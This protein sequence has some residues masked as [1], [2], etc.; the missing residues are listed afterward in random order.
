M[1]QR[2]ENRKKS[3]W[4]QKDRKWFYNKT[5]IIDNMRTVLQERKN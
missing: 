1:E 3:H 2:D 5:E 4:R